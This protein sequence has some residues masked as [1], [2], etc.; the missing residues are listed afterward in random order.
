M[1]ELFKSITK[2]EW[3][4]WIKVLLALLFLTSLS[5]IFIFI[6]MPED[7]VWSGRTYFS[8]VDRY[9]YVSYIEQVRSGAYLL[10]D[11]YTSKEESVP[12]LNVF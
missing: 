5:R 10:E 12:M 9:V 8:P 11:L 4:F 6:N 3:K 2:K 7:S 1:V